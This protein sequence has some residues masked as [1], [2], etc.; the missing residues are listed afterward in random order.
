MW[1]LVGTG[2]SA[3]AAVG[4]A[5]LMDSPDSVFADFD[6]DA[7]WL[8][9]RW[10]D[11]PVLARALGSLERLEAEAR[12]TH[13][14]AEARR[15]A[16]YLRLLRTLDNG[17]EDLILRAFPTAIKDLPAPRGGA[18]SPSYFACLE[19]AQRLYARGEYDGA[20]RYLKSFT[21]SQYH[22]SPTIIARSLGR[23]YEAKGDRGRAAEE[24]G[25]VARWWKN[26][27]PF[28]QP[29]REE[30]LQALRRVTAEPT[31]ALNS[32]ETAVSDIAMPRIRGH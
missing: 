17:N 21:A 3:A 28:L 11:R 22:L 30:A 13:D 20:E 6:V 12:A 26:A 10:G 14:S 25:K 31:G 1:Y 19:M 23:V 9:L 2:D 7:G 16:A 29:L 24:Y 5:E 18:V 8:A 32:S 27:D 4:L 15:T